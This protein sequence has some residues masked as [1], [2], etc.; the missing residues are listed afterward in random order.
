MLMIDYNFGDEDTIIKW[1]KPLIQRKGLF[2]RP[3]GPAVVSLPQS[4]EFF[5]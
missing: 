2:D 3:N 5:L 1:A 4:G